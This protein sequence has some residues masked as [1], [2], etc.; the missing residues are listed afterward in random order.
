MFN[1]SKELV[2][3]FKLSDSSVLDFEQKPV[4]I[5]EDDQQFI[6]N[7]SKTK[8]QYT[9]KLKQKY[10]TLM[11]TPNWAK[12]NKKVKYEDEDD[13]I[14]RTVGHTQK[15]KT[16]HLPKD[17]LEI[18]RLPLINSETKN[19][20]RFITQIQFHPKLSVALVA[21]NSG[22]V[23]LFSVGGEV[24]NKLH[25][26]KLKKWKVTAAEF[27]P[28]GT[29]AYLASNTNHSYCVYDLVKAEPKLI[30]LPQ[31]VKKP[32][33]F[34][35]SPDGKYIAVSDGFDELFIIST[36]SK[37]LL[38]SL[39][40]NSFVEDVAF[41][42]NSEKLYCYCVQGEVTIWDLSTFKALK[43]FTDNGCVNA[44]CITASLCGKLLAT[45][46]REG[47]VNVY[48]T[49]KLDT[50][51]P[52]PLKTVSN[53]TTKITNLRF[54]STTE[55]LAASSAVTQNAVKLI[56]IPS[57]HVFTNFPDQSTA[58][59]Q[60]QTVNFSPNSGYMSV[61]NDKGCANFYRLKYYKN[62]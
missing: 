50:V 16:I 14:L 53:L 15:R 36:A 30:Q 24:N 10:E 60:V 37:E 51:E 11:G 23:S 26:F 54:N 5:D 57:Y 41:H 28:S 47:I 40:H 3:K 17:F 34:K 2:E 12:I 59:S 55:I 27:T 20:G 22:I 8:A 19:E 9:E 62:Y 1:Q 56:H 32:K 18:K 58:L 49:V 21:G 7:N 38:K 31:I 35:L 42:Y 4:W 48:D 25:S 44:S 6:D 33:I 52:M 43:K 61:G 29:E 13:E 46:S 39:K 45:G